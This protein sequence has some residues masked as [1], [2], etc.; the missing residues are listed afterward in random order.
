M[1]DARPHRRGLRRDRGCATVI[2][3]DVDAA[4]RELATRFG[5]TVVVAPEDLAAAAQEHGADVIL[6]L[7]GSSRAVRAAF[8]VVDMGG[9]VALIG[10]VSPAPEV[11]FEPSGFVKNLTSLVGCHN[12]RVDDLVEAVG[13]LGR[14]PVQRLFGELVPAPYALRDI[15]AAVAAS[16][17]GTAPRIAVHMP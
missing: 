3:S 15:D 8:G 10:S 16:N 4:R 5:A 12:Y 13:F 9:R 6:E 17:A 11:G 7:S 1:R 2:A 14:T